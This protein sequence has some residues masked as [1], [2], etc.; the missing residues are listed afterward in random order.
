MNGGAGTSFLCCPPQ[1]RAVTTVAPVATAAV[2]GERRRRHW[3]CGVN[4]APE[5]RCTSS[6]ARVHGIVGRLAAGLTGAVYNDTLL[7]V[8]V[9]MVTTAVLLALGTTVLSLKF[10]YPRLGIEANRPGPPTLFRSSPAGTRP[11]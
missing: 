8:T 3:H 5:M 1:A 11:Q 6:C 4:P 10:R 7:V 2:I 9:V